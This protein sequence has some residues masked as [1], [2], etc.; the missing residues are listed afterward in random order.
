VILWPLGGS[1]L[2]PQVKVSWVK[3]AV[4]VP[5]RAAGGFA[6]GGGGALGGDASTLVHPPS[7]LDALQEA[8]GVEGSRGST[9]RLV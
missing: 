4:C 6:W 3:A 5:P 9:G 7:V 2:R 1:V 8:E